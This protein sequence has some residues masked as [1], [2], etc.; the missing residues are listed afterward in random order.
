VRR[1]ARG[2]TLAVAAPIDQLFLATEVNEWALCAAFA[3]RDP[4]QRAAL[5]SALAAAALEEAGS[6][7]AT[8][9]AS[10]GP[11]VLDEGAALA[12][13][14]V[15]S[16]LE[17]NPELEAVL[18][19]AA[20]R[21]LNVILDDTELTVG[22]GAGGRSFAVGALPAVAAIPWGSLHDV[23]TALVTG[24]NGKTTTVR[25]L[26]AC[27]RAAGLHAGY[28]C[29][30]GVFI[31]DDGLAAGDYSGPAGARMV[32]R[33]PLTQAAILETARGG[34]LRRGIAVAHADVAVVTNVSADHFGEYGVDDL[35]GLAAVKLSVAG[36]VAPKGLLVLNADDEQLLAQA[37]HLAQRF[38]SA[39]RLAWF[40][41]DADQETLRRHR[42]AGGATCGVRDGRLR[43]HH[44][45][46]DH[47]LG[48]VADLPLSVGGV[49]TYNIA[50]LA[51]AALG[52]VALGIGAATIA[53]VFRRF[54]SDV[55]D[56]PG[57]L[58]RF[59]VAG[60]V[61]LVDYAHNPDGLRGLLTV[62]SHLRGG[63]RLGL[64]LGHAGNRRDADIEEVKPSCA[65][66]RRAKCRASF[67][68]RCCGWGLRMPRCPSA[69]AKWRRRNARSIGR[70][71]AMCWPCP[72][73]RRL[74]ARRWWHWHALR[75][76]PPQRWAQRR[77]YRRGRM[78]RRRDPRDQPAF[79]FGSSNLV[80]ASV[81]FAV[82][83]AM[84][85]AL[86]L[87]ALAMPA[88]DSVA[89]VANSWARV[90]S[91]SLSDVVSSTCLEKKSAGVC[92]ARASLA[93]ARLQSR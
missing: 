60:V 50:N 3:R 12:R 11:P 72:C 89:S 65:A 90:R 18:N 69:A 79:F 46:L 7:A 9:M 44:A 22:A 58:M 1:H 39:P 61:V 55:H 53:A 10:A 24:S 75:Q 85:L 74:R 34:I 21:G 67:M 40:A 63:G 47:D 8:G 93:W 29:T 88:W 86:S 19:E 13:F 64:L 4:S 80:A 76:P 71:R 30:D 87:T 81:T 52:A 54:G 92:A 43:L 16:G 62:A 33:S 49:A 73:T 57:R 15:L 31:D 41:L 35:A 20:A 28:N 56:N 70:A 78:P 37:P 84:L 36:A 59:D 66:G 5:E 45:S 83:A 91:F 38:G 48:A 27:A 68:P 14:R 32:M 26:A 6:P 77:P 42:S 17:R 2:T 51:A 23:P 82:E 25:L